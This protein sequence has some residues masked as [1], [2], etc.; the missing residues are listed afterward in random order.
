VTREFAERML[1]GLG[2]ILR[3]EHNGEVACLQTK[4]AA[5]GLEVTTLFTGLWRWHCAVQ[6]ALGEW[7]KVQK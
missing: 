4:A 5:G 2:Y 7:E 3:D 6:W 1:L